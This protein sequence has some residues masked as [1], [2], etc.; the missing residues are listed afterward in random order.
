MDLQIKIPVTIYMLIWFTNPDK[1]SGSDGTTENSIASAFFSSIEEADKMANALSGNKIL[2]MA[3]A[4]NPIP[5]N[6]V[7][8]STVKRYGNSSSFDLNETTLISEQ[9]INEFVKKFR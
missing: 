8:W 3:T 6:T 5:D 2:L 4:Q 9:L 1:N 7:F